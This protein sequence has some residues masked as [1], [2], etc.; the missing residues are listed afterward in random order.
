MKAQVREKAFW[1]G[2]RTVAIL[3]DGTVFTLVIGNI[4]VGA[5]TKEQAEEIKAGVYTLKR[6]EGH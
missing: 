6:D 5:V 1:V 2:G 4:R 3:T